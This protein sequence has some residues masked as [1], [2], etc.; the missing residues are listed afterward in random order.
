M[1]YFNNW[2]QHQPDVRD[3]KHEDIDPCLCTH[4]IYSF[5]GIWENN[6]TMTKRKELDD[7]KGFNDLK[8]R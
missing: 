3:I 6:F 4:L 7:Y 5:A 8:K 1:C 2:P